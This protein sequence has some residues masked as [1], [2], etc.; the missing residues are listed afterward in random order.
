M[1]LRGLR[2]SFGSTMSSQ[3]TE[4]KS[5][6]AAETIAAARIFMPLQNHQRSA[7]E[8]QACPAWR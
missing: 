7:V 2:D 4:T 8:Q 3:P 1:N 5:A 6:R